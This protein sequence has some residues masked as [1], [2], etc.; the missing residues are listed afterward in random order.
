MVAII[1]LLAAV[2]GLL[3][4]VLAT[5]AKVV[6]VGRALMWCGCLVTLFVVASHVVKVF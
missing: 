2:I 4:Y 3:I 1:P 6:E 5:N